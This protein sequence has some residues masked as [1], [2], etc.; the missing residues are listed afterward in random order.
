METTT[1]K[2]VAEARGILA[3]YD[4]LRQAGLIPEHGDFFPSVHYPPITR[5]P[6]IMEDQLFAGYSLPADDL[7]SV[8]A[9]IPFC[10][11]PCGFCHI[12]ENTT[13]RPRRRI[14]TWT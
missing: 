2:V 13:P 3:D 8:Y 7:L 14:Y 6:R 10:I 12:Q 1:K 9:H 4:R 11:R 5:Y